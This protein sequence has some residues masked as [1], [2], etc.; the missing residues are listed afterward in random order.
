M[1][2]TIIILTLFLFMGWNA[3]WSV[4][5]RQDIG[6]SLEEKQVQD[7]S[8][9][10]LKLVFYVNLVNSS[11][12]D[13]YLSRYSYRFFTG[14][15]EYLRM[16]VPVEQE[17]K[18]AA[19]ESTMIALPVKITYDLLFDTAPE[20]KDSEMVQC[21]IK[22]E[23]E[24]LSER[25]RRRVVPFDFKGE[26]PIF[27]PP[28]VNIQAIKINDLTIAGSDF[29]LQVQ[30]VNKNGFELLV[31]K[32]HYSFRI[33]GYMI[34]KG[35][36]P[37]D[38]SIEKYGKKTFSLNALVNFYEVGKDIYGFFQLDSVSCRFS[39]EIRLDTVWGIINLPYDIEK[40]TPLLR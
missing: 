7:L 32:I 27:T 6:I 35:S 23:F 38:K 17:L 28:E 37:G 22:G 9:S 25:R 33:G 16:Q 5:L 34:S 10:G 8:R 18:I 20:T 13:Y 2:R 14:H 1:K 40:D 24:F 30:F 29:D 15:K 4:G 3:V 11:S 12:Q 21:Y 36:I 19:M 39:G 26:F 31:N